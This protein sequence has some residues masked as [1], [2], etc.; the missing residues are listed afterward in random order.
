MQKKRNFNQSYWDWYHKSPDK[1]DMKRILKG[2]DLM[3]VN[4]DE[5]LRQLNGRTFKLELFKSL[6]NTCSALVMYY[7]RKM[8]SQKK[9]EIIV[10]YCEDICSTQNIISTI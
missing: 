3:I 10:E 4:H 8:I 2:I 1:N 9:R 7:L 6:R 5:V